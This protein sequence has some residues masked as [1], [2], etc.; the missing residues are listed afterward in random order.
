MGRDLGVGMSLGVIE[1]VGLGVGVALGEGV[2]VGEG[3]GVGVA[4]GPDCTQ[5][6]PPLF[7]KLLPLCPPQTII[8]P[9]LET[10]V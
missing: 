10:A 3:V 8:S 7:T 5:Y 2:T 6:L 4:I 1:G 9:S